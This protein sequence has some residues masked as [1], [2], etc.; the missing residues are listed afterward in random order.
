M[1]DNQGDQR[2]AGNV[3]DHMLEGRRD[4]FAEIVGSSRHREGDGDSGACSAE[5]GSFGHDGILLSPARMAEELTY[6]DGAAIVAIHGR[7]MAWVNYATASGPPVS[8]IF[9]SRFRRTA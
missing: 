9:S 8:I 3:V 6:K 1:V 7:S 4:F 5:D 2:L